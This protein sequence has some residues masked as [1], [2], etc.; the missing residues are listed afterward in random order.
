M[1]GWSDDAAG[2]NAVTPSADDTAARGQSDGNQVRVPCS[3]AVRS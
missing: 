2:Q 1:R 3:H